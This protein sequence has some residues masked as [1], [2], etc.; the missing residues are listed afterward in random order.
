MP[1]TQI[2][3]LPKIE[4]PHGNLTFAEAENQVPFDIIRIILLKQKVLT[5]NGL[6]N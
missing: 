5:D 4:D 6:P 2:I 1:Q 3:P